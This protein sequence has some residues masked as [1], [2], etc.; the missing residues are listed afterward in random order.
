[1]SWT[2]DLISSANRIARLRSG[3]P[4]QLSPKVQ[5]AAASELC[6]TYWKLLLDSGF[7][8]DIERAAGPVSPPDQV[9]INSLK[10]DQTQ[11]RCHIDEAIA[12]LVEAGLDGKFALD[13][14]R[15]VQSVISQN[16]TIPIE[17]RAFFVQ[18][19]DAME[20]VCALTDRLRTETTTAESRFKLRKAAYA[21]AGLVI[22]G[23]TGSALA[24]VT[25]PVVAAGAVAAAGIGAVANAIGSTMFQHNTHGLKE[26]T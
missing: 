25:G 21:G 26:P 19:R 22:V 14:V 10:Q 5:A 4:A 6:T 23:L 7:R 11:L 16:G 24:I 1:M 3:G 8:Q 13:A 17:P 15:S 18:L 2:S 12:L 20:A 9:A